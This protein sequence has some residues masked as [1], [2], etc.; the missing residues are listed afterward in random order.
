MPPVPTAPTG[1]PDLSAQVA[2]VLASPRAKLIPS[3]VRQLV[4][5]LADTVT[6]QGK[7]LAALESRNG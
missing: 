7:R 5:L 1:A 3:D 4:Q 2:T 6:D